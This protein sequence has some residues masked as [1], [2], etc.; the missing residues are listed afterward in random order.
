MANEART[1]LR[2]MGG[3][4]ASSPELMQAAGY[5]QGGQVTPMGPF[6][7][8]GDPRVP[9]A[10]RAPA[11]GIETMVPSVRDPET[12]GQRQAQRFRE[13]AY[14]TIQDVAGDYVLD[15]LAYV[16]GAGTRALGAG[17][18]V[19]GGTTS[20]LGLDR[21]S[22]NYESESDRLYNRGKT[23]MR[24]GFSGI[25]AIDPADYNLEPSQF[26]FILRKAQQDAEAEEAA[27]E[28]QG[29]IKRSGRERAQQ[30][31]QRVLPSGMRIGEEP[32]GAAQAATEA[33]A[34]RVEDDQRT[35][36]DAALRLQETAPEELLTLGGKLSEP[37]EVPPPPEDD[38]NTPGARRTLRQRYDERLELFKDIFGESDEAR[39]RDRAMSL[40]ML[41]LAI[42]SG[43]SPNALSNIAQGAM[44]GLQG[45]SEQERARREREQGLQQAALTSVMD[46]MGVEQEAARR[47]QE[48]KDQFDRDVI[49]KTL[50]EG[51]ANYGSITHPITQANRHLRDL[52]AEAGDITSALYQ[53][54]Q[55]LPQAAQDRIIFQR[56]QDLMRPVYGEDTPS[57]D[58]LATIQQVSTVQG[59]SDEELA[60][61]IG[62]E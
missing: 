28:E 16:S 25:D 55:G 47:A 58:S 37:T 57:F 41:G 39:A 40:A 44:A 26:E 50:G 17:L 33:D 42:A 19:L 49:L 14:D 12:R 32:E 35:R 3:I 13:S 11:G 5:Q 9:V 61:L 52:R 62:L 30:E 18:D 54:L 46:E 10:P 24:S 60:P 21:I 8:P 43:Q 53:Q 51:G 59:M 27:A 6:V 56:V 4:M 15:P 34:Q 31:L 48:A 36:A 23:L 45:M 38:D 2:N 20:L 22:A 29:E 7:V 1:K